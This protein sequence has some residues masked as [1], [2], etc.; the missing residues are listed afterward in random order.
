MAKNPI[1]NIIIVVFISAVTSLY[2]SGTRDV[3]NVTTPESVYERVMRTGK[4]RC[5]YLPWAHFIEI[6]ANTGALS[7]VTY[8]YMETLAK[9]LNLDIEWVEEIG[10]GDYIAALNNDRFDA[11]CTVVSWNAERARQADFIKP[12][13]FETFDIFVRHDDLR[14]DRNLKAI[15]N[16]DIRIASVEGDIFTKIVRQ[17]FPNATLI[18]IPQLSGD[19]A[20]LDYLATNKADIVINSAQVGVRYMQNN[21]GKIRKVI[22]DKPFRKSPASISI[23]GGEFRFKRMLDIAT[24]EMLENGSISRIWDKY[25]PDHKFF[26]RAEGF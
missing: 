2:V 17:E 16:K 25:D 1:L 3:Q 10:R 15:N 9:N 24:T 26:L 4:I 13:G 19:S 14:F 20:S 23:K 8:D 21:P 22:L 18:E 6:D 5:G 11:Y 12:I 7:G